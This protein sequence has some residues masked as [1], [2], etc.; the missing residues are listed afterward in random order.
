MCQLRDEDPDIICPGIW[1]CT[2]GGLIENN[3]TPKDAILRELKE[4]FE[5]KV[6]KLESL[7]THEVDNGEYQGVYHA[8][9]ADM[10][11]PVKDVKC[12]EGQR[13]E[14]FL[15]EEALHLPQHPVS[16]IFLKA[17]IGLLSG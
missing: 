4:E 10:V 3:E 17:Y 16:L 13:A 11:T 5:I 7:L 15:P 8:F 2:P 14:F 9:L 1:S 12:N 6:D